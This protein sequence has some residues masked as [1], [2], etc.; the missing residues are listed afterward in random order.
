MI[1]TPRLLVPAH[2]ILGEGPIWHVAEQA[3]YWL[4]IKGLLVHRYDPADGASRSWTVPFRIGSLAPRAGGGFVGGSDRGIVAID[5]D[6]TRFDVI[7]DPEAHLPGNRFNDGKVDPAGHFW[8]GTMDDAEE[9]AT[10]SLYHLDAEGRCRTVDSDYHVTNGP[11]FSPDGTTLYHSDS[12]QQTVYAFD[13]DAD[14]SVTNRRVFARFGEGEGYPDG[15]TVDAEGCVW[16]AFWDGWCLRRLSPDGTVLATIDMPV[17]RPTSCAFGGAGLDTLFVTSA[18]I[19]LDTEAAP[20]AGGLFE[21][22][23]GVRGIA[24]L[25]FAG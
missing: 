24:P 18:A 10:G 3:L 1:D 9:A 2:A 6:F 15:M 4:D 25:P 5:A 17:Q 20:A 13:R 8:A 16:I 14:G 23:P 7:A 12:A 11:A 22:T 21:V 19:G